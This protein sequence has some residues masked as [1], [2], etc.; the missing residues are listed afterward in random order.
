MGRATWKPLQVVS[1][2]Y[3]RQGDAGD[4]PEHLAV[5]PAQGMQPLHLPLHIPLPALN[6][7]FKDLKQKQKIQ[8]KGKKNKFFFFN[9][10]NFYFIFN[11]FKKISNSY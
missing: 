6:F 3:P 9:C 1:E 7:I 2:E 5:P 10:S 4:A 11:F 8:K